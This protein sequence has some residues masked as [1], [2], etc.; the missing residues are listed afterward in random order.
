MK[1]LI[2]MFLALCFVFGGRGNSTVSKE[3]YD[4]VVAERDEL[5]NKIESSESDALKKTKDSLTSIDGL[6]FSE[7]KGGKYNVLIIGTYSDLN[8]IEET[9]ANIQK[10]SEILLPMMKEEWFEYD[11]VFLVAWDGTIGAYN[12]LS[13]NTIDYSTKTLVE[14]K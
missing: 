13:I 14:E 9:K 12:V 4:M 7:Q 8:L 5:K 2:I 11:Y 3:E 10:F 6:S 1:K